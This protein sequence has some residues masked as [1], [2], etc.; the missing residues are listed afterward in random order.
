MQGQQNKAVIQRLYD[1]IVNAGRLELVDEL[2]SPDFIDHST[3]TQPVGTLGVKAYLTAV[4]TGF[5]DIQVSIDVLLAEDEMVAIRTTWRGT[6]LGIY[7]GHAATGQRAE[8]TMLQMF[9]LHNG[10][11]TEEWNEGGSILP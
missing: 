8:R 7:E 5:P 4:R 2:F 6:H 10:K 11:I 3:P 1:Q 9:R